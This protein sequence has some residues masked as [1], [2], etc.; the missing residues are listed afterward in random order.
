MLSEAVIEI[1]LLLILEGIVF[2]L[3][4]FF[5]YLLLSSTTAN[6]WNY[7]LGREMTKNHVSLCRTITEIWSEEKAMINMFA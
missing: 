1:S 2:F 6:E 4:A 7:A 3:Q 5:L